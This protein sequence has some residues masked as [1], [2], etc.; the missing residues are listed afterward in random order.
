MNYPNPC[1]RCGFCCLALPCPVELQVFGPRPPGKTCP[2][3]S[4]EGDVAKCGLVE[5][6]GPATL[7]VGAGCCVKATAYR[8][9]RA[10]DF[11]SLPDEIKVLVTRQFR[12]RSK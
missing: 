6:L 9:G 12:E 3:L 2:A 8:N 5:V 1:N 11:A 10:Y 4:F 7:G